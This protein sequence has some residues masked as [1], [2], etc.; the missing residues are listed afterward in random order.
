VYPVV[1][2]LRVGVI[3]KDCGRKIE[4][5]DLYLRGVRAAEMAAA[6][7]KPTVGNSPDLV[8][9]AWQGTLTCGNPDCEKTHQ[10]SGGD[11]LLYED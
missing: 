1:V 4:V 11:L 5:E 10:Y 6:L 9:A 8:N 3:C 2:G 7:Y